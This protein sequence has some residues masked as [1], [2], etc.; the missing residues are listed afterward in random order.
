MR[1]VP[2]EGDVSLQG[3]TL[4]V[5]GLGGQ[6]HLGELCVDALVS[7]WGLRRVAI[8]QSRHLLPVAMASAWHAP[9]E[10][11]A[12]ELTLTTAAELY[13]GQARPGLSVLQLRSSVAEGRRWALA[14]ELW[15]WAKGAGV[16]ELVVVSSCAAHVKVDADLAAETDL[17]FVRIA[18]GSSNGKQEPAG[19]GPDLLPLGFRL[20]DEDLEEGEDRHL[21]AARR[22]LRGG[23]L[24]RPLLLLASGEVADGGAA[25][26]AAAFAPPPRGVGAADAGAAPGVLCL[27]GFESE[28]FNPRLVEQLSQAALAQLAGGTKVELRPPPSWRL[29]FEALMMPDRRIWG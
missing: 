4:V 23:G 8:A 28:V 16:T 22:V 9:G 10:Q 24:A 14:R 11:K 26:E 21:A 20:A 19:P 2:T 18:G 25:A 7:S 13:Q 12:G 1:V 17:R 15:A 3:H 27:L 6:S 29:L 5:P